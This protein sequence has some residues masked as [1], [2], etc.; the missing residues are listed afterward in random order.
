MR[1]RFFEGD[2]GVEGVDVEDVLV[3]PETG[4]MTCWVRLWGYMCW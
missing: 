4:C 1:S 2:V 3:G